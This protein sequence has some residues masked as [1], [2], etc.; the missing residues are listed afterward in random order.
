MPLYFLSYVTSSCIHNAHA[1]IYMFGILFPPMSLSLLICI[2]SH[3]SSSYM[4]AIYTDCSP[5][6]LSRMAMSISLLCMIFTKNLLNGNKNIKHRAKKTAKQINI[7]T[8]SYDSFVICFDHKTKKKQF[9][10]FHS[11]HWT[12]FRSEMEAHC[13]LWLSCSLNPN[14]RKEN[15][16]FHKKRTVY[17]TRGVKFLDV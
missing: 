9:N 11:F 5:R 7:C 8:I 2:R 14:G 13:V 1:P 16:Q 10:W 3:E 15:I 12:F 17:K 4:T 6:L